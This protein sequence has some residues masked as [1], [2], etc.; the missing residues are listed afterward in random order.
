M[1]AGRVLRRPPPQ[2]IPVPAHARLVDAGIAVARAVEKGV[3]CHT[4]DVLAQG[5]EAV[6][7]V[8]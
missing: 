4:H 7:V 1:V 3:V 8:L 2:S 6:H 5:V